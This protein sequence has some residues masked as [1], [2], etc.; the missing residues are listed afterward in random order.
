MTYDSIVLLELWSMSDALR[1]YMSPLFTCIITQGDLELC[2]RCDS[3]LGI[4][5]SL[6]GGIPPCVPGQ[7]SILALFHRIRLGLKQCV[8]LLRLKNSTLAQH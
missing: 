1:R 7:L 2:K 4:P 3:H 6:S 5:Y 8:G